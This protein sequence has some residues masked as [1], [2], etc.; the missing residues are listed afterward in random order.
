MVHPW[1]DADWWDMYTPE[2]DKDRTRYDRAIIAMAGLADRLHTA[3]LSCQ[4]TDINGIMDEFL[5]V[6]DE[7]ADLGAADSESSMAM[8]KVVEESNPSLDE[9]AG[10]VRWWGIVDRIASALK[11][12]SPS[13]DAYHGTVWNLLTGDWFEKLDPL[14]AC[15]ALEF[16]EDMYTA[17]GRCLDARDFDK[18]E[19]EVVFRAKIELG[20]AERH[21]DEI[22]VLRPDAVSETQARAIVGDDQWTGWMDPA[23]LWCYLLKLNGLLPQGDEIAIILLAAADRLGDGH[24]N[25][26]T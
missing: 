11:T 17:R 3:I 9:I 1:H 14:E 24:A 20:R 26:H 13:I 10:K 21:G 2:L 23:D 8:A 25:L 12:S 7:Y 4:Y 6:Q 15:R 18:G 16:S 5:R 22:W 19:V